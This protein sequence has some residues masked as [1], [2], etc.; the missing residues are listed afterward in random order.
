MKKR[1]AC[2]L[3]LILIGCAA[4][5]ES[6]AKTAMHT[7]GPFSFSLPVDFD[8]EG[9]EDDGVSLSNS[10]AGKTSSGNNRILSAVVLTGKEYTDYD[11]SLDLL[12]RSILLGMKVND[13]DGELIAVNNLD[14][15]LWHGD[16]IDNAPEGIPV[17]GLLYRYGDNLLVLVYADNDSTTD[18]RIEMIRSIS[19]TINSAKPIEINWTI[20]S[21][22]EIADI[23]AAGQAEL[24]S[25][26]TDDDSPVVYQTDKLH[27]SVIGTYVRHADDSDYAVI[28]IEWTNDT[29]EPIMFWSSLLVEAYQ[30]GT[31]IEQHSPRGFDANDW[32]KVLPG[33]STISYA[34][35][36]IADNSEVVFDLDKYIDYSD[37]FENVYITLDPANAPEI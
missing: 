30:N 9:I 37:K 7:I 1:L 28:E 12:Y 10:Y 3:A 24:D 11:G 34:C 27:F 4:L 15:Y 8:E 23:L 26:H 32:T 19:G 14:A 17:A 25:R 13:P 36:P 6:D 29:D 33:Y 2:V 35:F 5:A 20:L 21:D 31:E 16:W 22:D 18:E